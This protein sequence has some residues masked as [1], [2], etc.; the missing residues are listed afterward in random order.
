MKII[1]HRGARGLAPENTIVGIEKA[2][3]HGANEIE[4][5]VRVTKD[6]VP[7]LHHNALLVD[8][9]GNEVSI[10]HSSYA[11]L[12]RHKPDLAALDH[13][14]R[15]I[16]HRCPVIIELKSG[17]KPAKVIAMIEYYRGKGWRLNEFH[18]TSFDFKILQRVHRELPE[19]PLIVNEAWS[20]VRAASRCRR[21]ETKRISMDQR[22]LWRWFLK[23]MQRDGY[24]ISPYA[25]NSKRRAA[26]W[27]PYVYGIITDYPDRFK[28]SK[29]SK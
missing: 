6:G 17:V 28:K 10:A 23:A 13:A 1:G 25:V 11:E 29:T 14:I 9:A 20:G 16:A 21:L 27:A 4:V 22:W 15:V 7:V 12:L 3:K 24:Q 2:I 5:D 26:K 18:I 8:A 19:L